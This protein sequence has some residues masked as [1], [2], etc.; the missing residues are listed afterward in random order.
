MQYNL[1]WDA[2]QDI[3]GDRVEKFGSDWKGDVVLA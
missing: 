1:G 3:I 2:R